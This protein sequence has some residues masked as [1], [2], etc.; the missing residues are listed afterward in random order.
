MAYYYSHHPYYGAQWPHAWS[1][2]GF[3][4]AY[5][6]YERPCL[7]GGSGSSGGGR[8]EDRQRPDLRD[9]GGNPHVINIEKAAEWNTDFRRAIWTGRHL[10]VVLM[11]IEPGSD[12][13]LEVHP[14][15]DQF[16]RIEEGFALVQM[17]PRRDNLNFTRRVSEDDAIMIPAGTWHNVT[18]IG[19]RPL[20]LYTIYAP[21][22]HR[23]GTV[24]RTKAEA[25]AAHEPSV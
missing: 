3:Y 19:P 10:Q 6:A 5:P 25:E 16:I 2:S 22:E 14:N 20:K 4:P 11:S 23:F 21:P 15:V 1:Y 7:C 24:H 18:N 8:Q 13:G 17:G 12:I 9:Y